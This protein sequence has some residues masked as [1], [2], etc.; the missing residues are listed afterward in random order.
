MFVA[1]LL[2]Y[3]VESV[4]GVAF[5]RLFAGAILLKST[6]SVMTVGCGG[7]YAG[8]RIRRVSWPLA[9]IF[10]VVCATIFNVLLPLLLHWPL[11]SGTIYFSIAFFS[12][13]ALGVAIGA[14]LSCGGT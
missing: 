6:F 14:K 3:V 5:G 13:G 4:L 9:G 8:W 12:A 2:I 11:T 1:I 7:V 10:G